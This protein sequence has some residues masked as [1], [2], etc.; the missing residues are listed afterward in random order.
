MRER[1][2]EDALP[3]VLDVA[4]EVR[5]ELREVDG[6]GELGRVLG[7]L[8]LAEGVDEPVLDV[9]LDLAAGGL[10]ARLGSK[11]VRNSQL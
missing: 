2:L 6:L 3:Q 10:R 8:L 5:R 7:A 9:L 1:V 11:R 4:L